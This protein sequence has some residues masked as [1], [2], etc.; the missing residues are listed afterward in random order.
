MPINSIFEKL[1]NVNTSNE[2]TLKKSSR[3]SLDVEQREKAKRD[4][5]YVSSLRNYL[6][7]LNLMEETKTDKTF[8]DQKIIFVHLYN[9]IYEYMNSY[10]YIH[11]IKMGLQIK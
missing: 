8:F 3:K 4:S 6:H 2:K 9:F 1:R 10:S 5:G 11:T 7:R